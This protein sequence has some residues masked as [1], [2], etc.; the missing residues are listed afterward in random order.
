MAGLLLEC[1]QEASTMDRHDCIL[2]GE[3]YRVTLTRVFIEFLTSGKG[4]RYHETLHHVT[5]LE[6][7]PDGV[8]VV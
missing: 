8:C 4:P 2:L 5:I 7:M 1:L 3:E 6:V